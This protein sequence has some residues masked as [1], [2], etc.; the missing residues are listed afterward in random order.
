MPRNASALLARNARLHARRLG[1]LVG[2]VFLA[3][4][5]LSCAS[6]NQLSRRS[7]ESMKAGQTTRAY[8]WARRALDK[9]P[10]NDQARANMTAAATVMSADWK[11]RVRTLAA[12]D[13]LQ[14]AEAALEFGRFRAE[15]A[16]YQVVL[17]F[18]KPFRD[19]ESRILNAAADH[20]YRA[21]LACL[22]NH[23]PKHA[24]RLFVDSGRFAP[25]FRD[26]ALRIPKAYELALTRVA[27]L[28]F[29]NQTEVP[30]LSK[31]MADHLYGELDDHINPREFQFTRL[32][33]AEEVYAKMT[34]SELDRLDRD[35]A[36]QIG[37]KL[38]ARCVV[39][40][41]YSGMSANS[42]TG[43]YHQK[44]YRHYTDPDPSVK[45]RDRYEEGN[46]TA[47]TREREVKIQYQFEVLD[48]DDEQTLAR[49][50]AESRAVANTIYSAFQ[51]RGSCDD[52]CL[53]PPALKSAD[54]KRAEQ[55]DKEWQAS[56]GNWTLSKVLLNARESRSRTRY[57]PEH[58]SEFMRASYI[59]PV[60][61]DDLPSPNDMA[62]I[63]L[64]GTWKPVYEALR[65][66][67]DDDRVPAPAAGSIS[68]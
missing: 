48:T 31:E 68:R 66:L 42:T 41:R 59:F 64:D 15:L 35:Q 57:R 29:A 1:A 4:L 25:G 51:A 33:D 43:L 2:L 65:E 6:S 49:R 46:F 62:L 10:M 67:D 58:R 39:W 18:D 47:V 21:A 12:N 44:I 24:Y 45:E 17:P 9:D 28:P 14:G 53:L 40:G 8:D 61:L 55:V 13:S 16:R 54:P 32:V 34:V 36:I 38:G 22:D 63:A 56:F 3:L 37:R 26:I 27:I 23:Q 30:G 60:F 19:D 52:Y 7:E 11:L 20:D 50:G 5:T